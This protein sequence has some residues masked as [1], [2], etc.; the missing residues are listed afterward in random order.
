MTIETMR[1]R[2]V[3][4]NR[5]RSEVSA[6]AETGVAGKSADGAWR[7][8]IV[9]SCLENGFLPGKSALASF[10]VN[11]LYLFGDNA[12]VAFGG[13]PDGVTAELTRMG[14]K[15]DADPSPRGARTGG[16]GFSRRREGRFDRA[17]LL[18]Q[19][20]GR[21]SDGDILDQLRALRRAVRPGGL[22]CFHVFD[23]DWALSLAGRRILSAEGRTARVEIGFD[24]ADGRISARLAESA[25]P[26]CGGSAAVK[27]WN[28][29]ELEALL[30]GAGLRL[31]R[32][33][34]DWEGRG[35][36][37]AATAPGAVTGRLIVVAAKPRRARKASHPSR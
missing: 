28:R 9:E 5:V 27:A 14:H 8:R 25:G 11:A 29:H 18:A 15:V 36:E 2:P 35:P 16:A 30:R 17:V 26:G 3:T 21:G 32:V 12:I 19:A 37:A 31:E 7:R 1:Q 24:P 13:A 33:Y 4:S 10:L 22:V 23:R 34:G 20:F 6:T